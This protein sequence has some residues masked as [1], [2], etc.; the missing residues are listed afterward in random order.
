MADSTLADQK[1]AG[2]SK[3]RILQACQRRSKKGWSMMIAA[4]EGRFSLAGPVIHQCC[5][6]Q[7]LPRWGG[8]HQCL[9][10]HVP[11]AAVGLLSSDALS[12]YAMAF[13]C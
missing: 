6:N 3:H 9:A 5:I 4:A 8:W 12:R 7:A 1:G 2:N 11:A 13:G 10:L